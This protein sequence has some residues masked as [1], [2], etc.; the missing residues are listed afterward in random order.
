MNLWGVKASQL[1]VLVISSAENSPY[2]WGVK[3][4]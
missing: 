1:K 3:I 2:Y 4:F